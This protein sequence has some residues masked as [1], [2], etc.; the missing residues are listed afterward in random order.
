[1]SSDSSYKGPFECDED[2]V[3]E[4][5]SSANSDEEDEHTEFIESSE[6]DPRDIESLI[7]SLTTKLVFPAPLPSIIPFSTFISRKIIYFAF[8]L[9]VSSRRKGEER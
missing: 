1:M 7:S 8:L 4:D 5:A 2:D 9:A 3:E 6:I